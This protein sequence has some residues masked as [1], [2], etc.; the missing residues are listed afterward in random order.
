MISAYHLL[1]Y[2][3]W[4]ISLNSLVRLP[5]LIR[6]LSFFFIMML[7]VVVDGTR[8]RAGVDWENYERYYSTGVMPGIE[9]GFAFLYGVLSAIGLSYQIALF[10]ITT[11]IYLGNCVPV[12]LYSRSLPAV[13]FICS[14]LCWF[15][16]SQ[17]QF[18]ASGVI[19]LLIYFYLHGRLRIGGW[20]TYG[21]V[22]MAL[23]ISSVIPLATLFFSKSYK[24]F[25]LFAAAFFVLHVFIFEIISSFSLGGDF[26]S[27]LVMREG[28]DLAQGSPV[29]GVLRKLIILSF[30]SF[31]IIKLKTSY[32]ETA[33]LRFCY[34]SLPVYFIGMFYVGAYASR[35]D[36]FFFISGLGFLI[37]ICDLRGRYPVRVMVFLFALT[38]VLVILARLDPV[39]LTL[40]IP[41]SGVFYNTN[42]ERVLF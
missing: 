16:G 31:F 10:F 6:D 5:R 21:M 11:A 36:T 27:K 24:L 3:S 29:L 13:V 34:M 9:P 20:V 23:H 28:G 37:G 17:R 42:Y 33:L 7:F 32:Q 2:L 26:V 41:Y 4:L 12:Y 38:M 18:L 35:L 22:A 25:F 1:V 8:Y 14:Q 30:F 15:S 39:A 40:F 19:S